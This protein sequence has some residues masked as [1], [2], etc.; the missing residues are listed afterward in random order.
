MIF[1]LIYE[2]I[3][4]GGESV[5]KWTSNFL[6]LICFGSL[7]AFALPLGFSN[8]FLGTAAVSFL[9]LGAVQY[10]SKK[11]SLSDKKKMQR[12]LDEK[13]LAYFSEHDELVLNENVT[14]RSDQANGFNTLD[15]YYQNE[16]LCKV[17]EFK[18]SFPDTYD[19]FKY[20][21]YT[22]EVVE[23]EPENEEEEVSTVNLKKFMRQ[24]DDLNTSITNTKITEDL[25]HT[26]AMIKFI[27]QILDQYPEKESKVSKL[28]YYY[29]PT[30][31]SILKNYVRLSDTNKMDPDF[32]EVESQLMK[33]IY[34]VNQALETMSATLCDDEILD[35]SSDMSVLETMLKKDGLVREGT[36]DELK[37]GE[38]N[39]ER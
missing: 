2:I 26:S 10:F 7:I 28:D 19:Y 21:I 23:T 15:V 11:K 4:F 12:Q 13:A 39:A 27:D 14:I 8:L 34:L 32:N 9:L 31:V 30:L 18:S 33:T 20:V 37:V 3:I 17:S 16:K 24:I 5:K 6:A 1:F 29:L 25:Y 22:N 35:L 38:N 36:I